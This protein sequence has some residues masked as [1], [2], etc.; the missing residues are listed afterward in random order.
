MS[1]LM[2]I[3]KKHV[4]DIGRTGKTKDLAGLNQNNKQ[5]NPFLLIFTAVVYTESKNTRIK[6]INFINKQAASIDKTACL[7]FSHSTIS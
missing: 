7:F 2:S 1:P 5:I 4:P 6:K 3:L